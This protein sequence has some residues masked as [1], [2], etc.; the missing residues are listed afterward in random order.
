MGLHH[1]SATLSPPNSTAGDFAIVTSQANGLAL[2]NSNMRLRQKRNW[3]LAFAT[4]IVMACGQESAHAAAARD[5]PVYQ[6]DKE[7]SHYS[8]L[9]QINTR[10]VAKLELAWTYHSSTNRGG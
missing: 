7:S 6:G 2:D 1:K 3:L 4:G 5:W 8:T 10:N 9:N